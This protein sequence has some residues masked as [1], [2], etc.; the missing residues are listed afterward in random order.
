MKSVDY[1]I[2]V[3]YI[4]DMLNKLRIVIPVLK[5]LVTLILMNIYVPIAI[6]LSMIN[7]IILTLA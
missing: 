5:R 4:K 3:N 2:P 7:G 1:T 6:F